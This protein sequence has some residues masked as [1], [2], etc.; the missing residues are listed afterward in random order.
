M[1]T[2]MCKKCG[3]GFPTREEVNEH[4][5]KDHPGMSV[6]IIEHDPDVP[7]EDIPRIRKKPYGK[8]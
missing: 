5:R 8:F 4:I 1:I 6:T 2:F 3:R 7:P